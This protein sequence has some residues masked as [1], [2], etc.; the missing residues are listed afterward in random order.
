MAP[1]AVFGTRKVGLFALQ[2][3]S[4]LTDTNWLPLPL[5]PGLGVVSTLL[6]STAT[7][8]QRFC[9]VLQW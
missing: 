6:D 7:D 1:L 4:A 3:K 2:Y 8:S 5:A 9:R